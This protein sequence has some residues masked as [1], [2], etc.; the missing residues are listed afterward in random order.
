[1]AKETAALVPTERI[2][3][4]ILFLRGQKVLLT[5]ILPPSTA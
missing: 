2:E 1:M 5:R 4:A 3:R